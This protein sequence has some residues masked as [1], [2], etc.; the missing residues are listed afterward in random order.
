MTLEIE[1]L[2]QAVLQP[3]ST[4]PDPVTVL[5]HS[6]RIGEGDIELGYNLMLNF[7]HFLSETEPAPNIVIVMNAGVKLVAEDSDALDS[8]KKL[9]AK[10]TAIL[11]CTTCLNFFGI[12]DRQQAGKASNMAEVVNVLLGSAKVITM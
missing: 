5:I 12:K 6:D 4:R 9:E 1:T 7:L 3:K 10:G 11:A 8:L 2:P